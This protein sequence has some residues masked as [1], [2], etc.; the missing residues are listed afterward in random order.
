MEFRLPNTCADAGLLSCLETNRDIFRITIGKGT[1]LNKETQDRLRI[2]REL[3]TTLSISDIMVPHFVVKYKS[4]A[5]ASDPL[6][7]NDIDRQ[8][9]SA[10]V[11]T[12]DQ[13][14]LLGVDKSNYASYG[15]LVNPKEG[16]VALYA[17]VQ[18]RNQVCIILYCLL[19]IY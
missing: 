6:L 19:L 2:I 1:F 18:T 13:A 10:L 5:S 4:S 12:L 11:A 7:A 9:K 15:A 8:L 16:R 17:M 14:I 3:S